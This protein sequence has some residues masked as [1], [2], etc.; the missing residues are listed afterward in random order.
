MIIASFSFRIWEGIKIYM[1]GD[2]K[3]KENKQFDQKEPRK[4]WKSF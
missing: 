4:N 3:G 1:K 2:D